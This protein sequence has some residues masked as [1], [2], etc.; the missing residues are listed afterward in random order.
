MS[1]YL[2]DSPH[3]VPN[4]SFRF[5]QHTKSLS[6]MAE[7]ALASSIIAVLQISGTVLKSAFKYLHGAKDARENIERVIV[8]IGTIES[9]LSCL[10]E[11]VEKQNNSGSASAPSLIMLNEPGG[12][13][14]QCKKS[15]ED[16]LRKL[17]HINPLKKAANILIWSLR[18]KEIDDILKNIERQK[19]LFVLAL[20]RDQL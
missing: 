2:D 18:E 16:L 5:Q 10:K 13:L 1:G 3:R 6:T 20:H 8:G 11:L 4:S 9:V 17:G 19:S 7:L 15:L 12:P 14:D